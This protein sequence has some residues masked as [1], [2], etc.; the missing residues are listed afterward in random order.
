MTQA[1]LGQRPEKL[2]EDTQSITG[3]INDTETRIGSNSVEN[4]E[5]AGRKATEEEKWK[6]IRESFKLDT[7]AIL[8]A[9]AKLKE[10]LIKMFLDN[11]EVLAT[12][13][14]Q[15]GETMKIDLVPGAIPYKSWLRL[16]NPDQKK[17]LRNQIEEW[18][19]QGVI[20]PSVSPWAS[21]LVP[22]KK[23]VGRTRWVTDLK[24]L[25]KQTVK[26][27]Y[28]LTNIQEILHSLHGVLIPRCMWSLSCNKNRAW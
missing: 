13:P 7:N 11:F 23:K 10:A 21:P 6:F 8:N 27:S 5:K 4:A 16:L 22:V 20:K 26:D 12:Y 18:L 3:R 28:P 1:E 25:N 19:E 9:D 2:K 24:E 17:N 15:Y 14:S